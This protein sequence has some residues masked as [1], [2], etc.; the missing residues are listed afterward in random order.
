MAVGFGFLSRCDILRIGAKS[1]GALCAKHFIG[2]LTGIGG[3]SPA[4]HFTCILENMKGAGV[5]ILT[6]ILLQL[7][8]EAD[9][10]LEHLPA[11]VAGTQRANG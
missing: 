8:Y 7:F 3:I 4:L 11:C 6:R 2:H 1:R 10:L 5:N 9:I